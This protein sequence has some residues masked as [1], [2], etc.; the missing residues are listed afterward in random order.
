MK[1]KRFLAGALAFLTL[2]VPMTAMAGPEPSEWA[3]E[4]IDKYADTFLKS[5]SGELDY[6]ADITREQF[7]ML[8]VYLYNVLSPAEIP[9]MSVTNPFTDCNEPLIVVAYGL[10]LTDGVSE[11]KFEPDMSITREQ[12]CTMLERMLIKCGRESE[13]ENLD[14]FKDAESV[15]EWAESGVK[16]CAALGLIQG[17][18]EGKFEPLSNCTVEQALIVAKRVRTL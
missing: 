1:I 6:T 5:S 18:D 3:V 13:E 12:M 16:T 14:G 17:T 11:N 15:S 4:E 2:S 9:E 7:A 8:T 10:G